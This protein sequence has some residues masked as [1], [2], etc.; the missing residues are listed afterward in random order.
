LGEPRWRK[1]SLW[2][3]NWSF[4]QAHVVSILNMEAKEWERGDVTISTVSYLTTMEVDKW[5]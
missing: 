2:E 4:V 5:D 1:P 3:P